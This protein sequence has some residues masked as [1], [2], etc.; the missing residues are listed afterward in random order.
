MIKLRRIQNFPVWPAFATLVTVASWAGVFWGP[1]GT[2]AMIACVAAAVAGTP[3]TAVLWAARWLRR[4]AMVFLI[5]SM[6]TQRARH[7]AQSQTAPLRLA[8]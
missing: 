4:R 8:Q 3:T 7:H 6:L 2:R 5:D 1:L